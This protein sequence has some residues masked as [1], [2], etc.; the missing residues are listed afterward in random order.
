MRLTQKAQ[1]VQNSLSSGTV[2]G[3]TIREAATPRAASTMKNQLSPEPV[4]MLMIRQTRIGI[5]NTPDVTDPTV[6]VRRLKRF[7][8]YSRTSIFSI[9]SFSSIRLSRSFA[10]M[11]RH[12]G[13]PLTW[14]STSS[15]LLGLHMSSA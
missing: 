15:R 7:S 6:A 1:K 14:F 9:C 5:M 10:M 13:H 2:S 8:P 12:S 3:T 11:F 4:R